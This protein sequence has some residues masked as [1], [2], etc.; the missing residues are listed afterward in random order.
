MQHRRDDAG[1][2]V[3]RGGDHPAAGGVFL[4][5]RQRPQVDPVHGAQRAGD[6]VAAAGLVQPPVEHRRAA[7]HLQPAGQRAFGLQAALHAG[8]HLVPDMRQAVA[9]F[10]I[11]AQ[12]AF[13]GPHQVADPREIVGVAQAQQLLGAVEGV[14]HRVVGQGALG[15]EVRL[16]DHETAAHRIADALGQQLPVVVQ[17]EQ[18]HAVGMRGQAAVVEHQVAG[19]GEV[20]DVLAVQG[21]AVLGKDG[22]NQRRQGGR[23]GVRRVDA[24]QADQAGAVGGV[25]LAGG[26][27]GAVQVHLDPRHLQQLADGAQMLDELAV[28]THRPHG[29]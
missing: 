27:E 3:G 5:H 19:R 20:D 1:G 18:A 25:A 22:I 4:V 16:V 14:G 15:V 21:Q 8:L 17:G 7:A 29:M 28:G 13:V 6:Q 12:G 23:V 10:R 9:D 24:E 26:A 11:A 2:A